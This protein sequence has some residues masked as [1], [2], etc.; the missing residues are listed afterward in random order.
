M[1]EKDLPLRADVR[2]LGEILG[3][4]MKR[5]GGRELFETEELIRALSK[6][7]R[8][9]LNRSDG[10]GST[11]ARELLALLRSLDGNKAIGVIRAF[12]VYFQLTN[13]AEQHHR[14]RRRRYYALET[15]E[16]P[17]PGSL[18]HLFTRLARSGADPGALFRVLESL[19]VELVITAHPTEAV[20]RSV[21]QKHRR[22]A[23]LL[24]ELDRRDLP[25]LAREQVVH[26]L[27]KE[28][29]SIWL[30]DE[31]RRYQPEVLDEVSNALYYF[32]DVLFDAVPD[33][34]E[35]LHRVAH[36]VPG[37]V[38]PEPKAPLRFGSWVGG[39]RDGNP[40][41]TAEVTWETLNRHR[42]LVLSKYR[43]S[44]D[45]LGARLS[46]SERHCPPRPRLVE[47]LERYQEKFPD[48][49]R[50]V[51]LR[52]P[53]E[54]YRQM[55]GYVRERL[56]RT[57]VG[58]REE[59]AYHSEKELYQDLSQIEE[60][61]RANGTQ[62]A[63]LVSRLMRQVSTFGLHLA[64]LDL[65]QSAARHTEALSEITRELGLAPYGE[66]REAERV[67]WL[68]SELST[69]RPL[70]SSGARPS[71][72]TR[73]TLDLFRVA[74][75]ALD[76]LSPSA[77]GTY[78]I[79]MAKDVSD[80]LA[81]LVLAKE[82]GLYQPAVGAREL[83]ARLR[84]APL[85]ET[86]EDLRGAPEVVS[87]LLENRAYA[88][89]WKAQ[90]NLQE[91]MVGYSDSCKD[92]GILTSSWELHKSQ[93]AL[94]KIARG[95]GAE[96]LLFHGR[97]GSVGRGGGPSH[98]AILA[99]PRGTLRGRIKITEQGEVVSSKYGL[100]EIALRSL[101]VATS[102]VI[103]ASFD[104][105]DSA[106]EVVPSV[107]ERMA[108]FR[109]VM[110]ELSQTAF[111]S[112][113]SVVADTSGFSRY[114]LDAT[115]VE[116]LEHLHIGSRPARRE[117]RS[118]SLADLRAIPW[119]FGWTQS[120]HLLPGWLGVGS[121]LEAF[122]E[123]R[124]RVH[125]ALLREMHRDWRFFRSMLSNI[126]MALAKA[127]FQIARH[128]AERLSSRGGRAIF[129]RLEEEYQTTRTRLLQVTE[130]KFLLEKTPVLRRSIE[131]RNPY[132]DPMSYLQV[133]LLARHRKARGKPRE[134]QEELLYAILLTI[135]GIAS[136]LR[137]TG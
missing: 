102:A 57:S 43:K 2:T 90:G 77:I 11:P 45:D 107:H 37:L 76:E 133:E 119:V 40:H 79:S 87:R 49:A 101:E 65:R 26:S 121:A 55:L 18:A 71:E 16:Q 34:I 28:V 104:F 89:V 114:F 9:G 68:T 52:N 103:E 124:P 53:H 132:V 83:V 122:A 84:V 4:C 22:I 31:L 75:R 41:V 5:H 51:L 27:E 69:P 13:I 86:I 32:D 113:R 35:E 67:E 19:A 81:V 95:H 93:E 78:V 96:L 3:D 58:S 91:V 136:G 38:L 10:R 88:P 47:A 99:Q 66:R 44:A 98:E 94:S 33:L 120:R 82:A 105:G 63:S 111:S 106:A 123:R 30:T 6:S 112:Y 129:E 116:E 118:T 48:L 42:A 97:G 74:R 1:A 54:P 21:L 12:A 39:D 7:L 59:G 108:R 50:R 130:Q 100:P 61:L 72:A 70:L 14:I 109:E 80:V 115:P 29:E 25:P 135:N 8:R 137:N 131:L 20:R 127:D 125:L 60:S 15:A 62:S 23:D 64:K 126:E 36:L 85:F 24:S 56:E 92:G 17:Q 128:Y 117:K 46:E 110:E 73:E 134:E